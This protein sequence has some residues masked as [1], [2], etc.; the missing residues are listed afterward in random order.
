MLV[1]VRP[2]NEALLFPKPLLRGVAKAALDCAHRATTVSSWGL[3]EQEGH[4]ATPLSSLS[5][6]NMVR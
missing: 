2:S 1:K 6:R 5:L 4:L 3:C